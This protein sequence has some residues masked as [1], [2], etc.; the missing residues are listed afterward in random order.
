MD[1]GWKFLRFLDIGIGLGSTIGKAWQAL[2]ESCIWVGWRIFLRQDIWIIL[3]LG[4]LYQRWKFIISLIGC[5]WE[6]SPLTI[7]SLFNVLDGCTLNVWLLLS[8]SFFII[9]LHHVDT[10]HVLLNL[11]QILATLTVNHI[12]YMLN[13]V[14]ADWSR[15]IGLWW[16]YIKSDL[17]D[18]GQMCMLLW[19]GRNESLL[20]IIFPD[21]R[22]VM[23]EHSNF[24]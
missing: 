10:G 21:L 16:V 8:T 2:D 6:S 12:K 24:W 18:W 14:W 23:S 22:Y 1:I 20:S 9:Y 5:S 15:S 11:L 3:L 17:A 7:R 4:W 13:L 19:S